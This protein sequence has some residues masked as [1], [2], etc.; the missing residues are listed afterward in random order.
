MSDLSISP[1]PPGTTRWVLCYAN[2]GR[3]AGVTGPPKTLSQELAALA[4]GGDECWLS[5][6]ELSGG[7]SDWRP[8]GRRGSVSA[9][10]VAVLT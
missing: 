9:I 10:I 8:S 3:S 7:S 6:R 5:F 4:A 2:K 1:A